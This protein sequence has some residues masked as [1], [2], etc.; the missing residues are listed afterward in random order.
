ML[1]PE[2]Q[3]V[4]A[5]CAGRQTLVQQGAEG[6]YP[7]ARPDHDDGSAAIDR[8]AE[9]MRLLYEYRDRNAI[10]N[11]IRKKRRTNPFARAAMRRMAHDA[12]RKMNLARVDLGTGGNRIK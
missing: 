1:L 4:A 3:P 2:E 6:S 9:P 11:Q 5:G 10:R 12:N 8:Q 7:S